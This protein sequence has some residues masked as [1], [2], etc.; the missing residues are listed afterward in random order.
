MGSINPWDNSHP[1]LYPENLHTRLR[2]KDYISLA[3]DYATEDPP[4]PCT[5]ANTPSNHLCPQ[6]NTLGKSGREADTVWTSPVHL[7]TWPAQLYRETA[8]CLLPRSD[9]LS[10]PFSFLLYCTVLSQSH[11]EHYTEVP[12]FSSTPFHSSEVI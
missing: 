8:V 6:Q 12:V 7:H 10:H 1:P 9:T 2:R 5:Q 11:C 4:T 3:S